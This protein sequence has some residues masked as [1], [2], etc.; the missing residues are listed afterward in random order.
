[1]NAYRYYKSEC[2]IECHKDNVNITNSIFNYSEVEN[3]LKQK[4]K[5]YNI[6]PEE[7]SETLFNVLMYNTNSSNTEAS[8]TN[9]LLNKNEKEFY[10]IS[11]NSK[12]AII[13]NFNTSSITTDVATKDIILNANNLHQKNKTN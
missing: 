11:K 7:I 3:L 6:F 12:Q 5:E 2:S 4:I 1:M 8:I 13:Y 10:L 9:Y